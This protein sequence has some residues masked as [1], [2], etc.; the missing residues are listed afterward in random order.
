MGYLGCFYNLAIVSRASIDIGKYLSVLIYTSLDICSRVV[1][2][3]GHKVG[4]FLVFL[5]L[6]H[7]TFHSSCTSLLAVVLVLFVVVY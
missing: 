7:T 2:G 5:R 1:W 4:L 6:L 3:A